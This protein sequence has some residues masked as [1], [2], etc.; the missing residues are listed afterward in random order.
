M[1]VRQV[2]LRLDEPPVLR[3]ALRQLREQLDIPTEYPAAALAEA[4][5]AAGTPVRPQRDLTDLDFLT[6]D[7]PGSTDLDQAMHLSRQGS[8]YLLRYAIADVAAFVAPG[9]ALD[10]ETHARGQTFYAP[11]HRTPLHPQVLSEGAASLLPGQ[12]RPALVWEIWMDADGQTTD[13]RVERA[14]VRSRRQLDY[15]GVQQA[16]DAGTGDEQLVLL[17]EI[18]RL[19]LHLEAARHGVSLGV[20]AQEIVT[21][22]ERWRLTFRTLLPVESWNAELSLATGMAAASIMLEGG[23]GILRT[24]PPAEKS[25]IAKLRRTAQ[26]LGIDWPKD[27]GYP[28]FVRSLDPANTRHAAMLNACTMLFRGASYAPFTGGNPPAQA[29]HAAIAAPYAHVTAP[30]RR[31]VDRYA[32]EICVALCADAAVPE[33]VLAGME[34]VAAEMDESNRRVKQYERGIIDRVEAM[35]LAPRLGAVFSGD[36]LEVDKEGR[37]GVM[38]LDEPA[39]EAP[40][41]G[42]DLVLGTTVDAT[43]VTADLMAGK[44]GFATLSTKPARGGTLDDGRAGPG[45]RSREAEESPDSEEQGGG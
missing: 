44:V 27:Q 17:A 38:Q 4:E 37:R 19:R 31:L 36:I 24:L 26:A 35:L 22:G 34:T 14:T 1:P 7:P 39:V 23:T 20:P 2:S 30:L 33:W 21:D 32:L 15:P 5:Q 6:I 12:V 28:D 3:A 42:D 18:G 40:V 11:S 41:T 8:G 25:G 9:G 16:I 13:A 45:D 10:A 43:L 29:V